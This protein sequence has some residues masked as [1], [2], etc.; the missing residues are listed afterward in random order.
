MRALL[1]GVI[2]S[3]GLA[4][5][6][7]VRASN[8]AMNF[9]FCGVL[10]GCISGSITT[11]GTLGALTSA[12][13]T[14]YDLTIQ[15]FNTPINHFVNVG[16]SVGGALYAL[17]GGLFFDFGDPNPCIC[18]TINPFG[19]A[20]P[21]SAFFI[22]GVAPPFPPSFL[23]AN[24]IIT[25]SFTERFY[26]GQVLAEIASETPVPPALPLFVTGLGALG[27]LGWR[28]KRKARAIAV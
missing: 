28:R 5:S 8:Y 18:M 6:T 11:D 1:Y 25:T 21:G 24:F 13:I 3:I 4:C 2:L 22:T 10:A 26:V 7:P 12:N 17:P 15:F 27:L 19:A 14:A 23:N 20:G 16:L 9:P